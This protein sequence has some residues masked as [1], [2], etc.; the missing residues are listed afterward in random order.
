M[1]ATVAY[2]VW[3]LSV[4]RDFVIGS[5]DYAPSSLLVVQRAASE[6]P[7]MGRALADHGLVKRALTAG[8]DP[9][10]VTVACPLEG[11]WCWS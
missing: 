6:S 4:G 3:E 5:Y 8:P 9:E 7:E 11:S 2:C 1:R 10:P